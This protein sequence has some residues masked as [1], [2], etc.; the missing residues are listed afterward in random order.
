LSVCKRRPL[1]DIVILGCN[2]SDISLPCLKH[3]IAS[4]PGVRYRVIFVDNG[5]TDTTP[6]MCRW[7]RA[8][9]RR[10]VPWAK[11]KGIDFVSVRNERN[12]GFSGGNN[13]G[14]AH[15]TAPFI[16]FM[17]N[18]AFPQGA[19]WLRKLVR[20]M[21][22]DRTLGAVGP[23]ADNVLGVQAAR[24]NDDWKRKHRSKFLSGVCVLVRRKLFDALGG[25][26]ERFFNGDEDLDLSIRIRQKGYSLGVVRDVFVEHLCSQT[27]QHIAAAN[28]KSINDWFAH[29]RSQL[30][31]K[32]GAAWHN[33]L[34]EWESLRLSPSY[35]NKVGVL[36]DGRYFQ[37]PGRVKD[38]IEALG[39]LRPKSRTST[40][41]QCE[42]VGELHTCYGIIAGGDDCYVALAGTAGEA[43]S[44]GD[45]AETSGE[46]A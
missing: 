34:F 2:R 26:D 16:L 18:D 36:P 1:V 3:L 31:E 38:Q 44:E 12:L 35:W 6:R 33:D 25:W 8:H 29:T 14:A 5:S 39:K 19:G 40:G 17:N 30:V 41:G 24:W 21:A 20:S 22:R 13:T 37:L 46:V 10:Y 43:R 45:S 32:H 7:F 23:T 11:Y 42:T 4:E 27:L 15:G 9:T 28:G